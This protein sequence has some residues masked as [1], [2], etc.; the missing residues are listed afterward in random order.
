MNEFEKFKRNSGQPK[1]IKIG[2]DE[3]TFKPLPLISYPSFLWASAQM[4]KGKS[5]EDKELTKEIFALLDVF[6]TNSYP[7]IMQD[8]ETKEAFIASN[9]F[10]LMGVM[11]EIS[12]AFV[13]NLSDTQKEQIE[14]LKAQ[15]EQ[16]KQ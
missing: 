14:K 9:F 8:K 4:E 1:T 10:N 2:E 15:Y 11:N 6:V 12:S 16:N 13:N 7:E 5:I 3:F